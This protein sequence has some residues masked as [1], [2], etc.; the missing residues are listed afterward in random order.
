MDD[1]R[2]NVVRFDFELINRDYKHVILAA[3]CSGSSLYPSNKFSSV[4]LIPVCMR[5]DH[6]LQKKLG[7][8]WLDFLQCLSYM[9]FYLI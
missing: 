9:F 6:I 4:D 7:I 5:K 8:R 1:P 2:I 3:S